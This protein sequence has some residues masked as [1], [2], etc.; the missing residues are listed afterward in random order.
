MITCQPAC[1]QKDGDVYDGT[2]AHQ[3]RHFQW[4]KDDKYILLQY[5][6]PG[7]PQELNQ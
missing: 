5:V 4:L 6:N 7:Y 2:Q 3:H 1:R